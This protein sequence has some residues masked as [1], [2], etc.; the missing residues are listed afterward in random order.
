MI[1]EVWVF[2]EHKGGEFHP[3][4][5]ELL[6]EARKVADTL[7]ADVGLIVLADVAG[8]P[9]LSPASEYGAQ[10]V[11]FLRH[12]ELETYSVDNSVQALAEAVGKRAPYL[13]IIGE[14][15]SGRE[16]SRRLAA[17]LKT[18][19]IPN[20]ARVQTEGNSLVFTAPMYDG[21]VE[22]NFAALKRPIVATLRPGAAGLIKPKFQTKSRV[23]E[24]PVSFTPGP[25]RVQPI[26]RLPVEPGS[27]DLNETDV[28]IGAGR[29]LGSKATFASLQGLA[30]AL[31]ASI[32]GTRR[33]ISLGW[34]S[35]DQLIGQTGRTISPE[36]YMAIGI[37]GASH[38]LVGIRDSKLIVAINTDRT[39]PILVQADLAVIC[40]AEQFINA[41]L[42]RVESLKRET[43]TVSK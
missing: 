7:K 28:V 11:Y 22:A 34:I 25:E 29:G 26:E 4:V 23:E 18:S 17:R 2:G 27:L 35:S 9:D 41:F 30:K 19:F 5:R 3:V 10:T 40:D 13:L 6:G 8:T 21:K 24:L 33:A 31:R 20:F 16:I 37:S 1:G 32:G 14:T 12:P 15:P 36:L 42:K 43:T 38:H 39:A